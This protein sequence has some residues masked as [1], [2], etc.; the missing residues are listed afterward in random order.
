MADPPQLLSAKVEIPKFYGSAVTTTYTDDNGRKKTATIGIDDWIVAIELLATEC[1]W[2]D[3]QTATRALVGLEGDAQSWKSMMHN[4]GDECITKWATDTG[5]KAKMQAWFGSDPNPA[6][7]VS[8][9]AE[10]KQGHFSTNEGVRAFYARTAQACQKFNKKAKAPTAFTEDQKKAALKMQFEVD[11]KLRFMAGLKKDL[12]SQIFMTNTQAQIDT[13]TASQ[14]LEAAVTAESINRPA[15]S[16]TT[17]PRASATTQVNAAE[18]K[19]EEEESKGEDKETAE[20]AAMRVEFAKLKKKDEERQATAA[21][22]RARGRGGRGRGRGRG[23]GAGRGAGVTCYECGGRGHF[24]RVCPTAQGIGFGGRGGGVTP[25]THPGQF[26]APRNT[27]HDYRGR[28]EED[29][30]FPPRYGPLN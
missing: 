8:L 27:Y 10:L 15:G 17:N 12:R 23:R 1:G 25:T 14:I 19:E 4:M 5:M 20:V 6:E 28:D 11:L 3:A 18:A 13:K 24:A 22:V 21:A 26:A 16:V 9:Q 29:D 7:I 30:D 2:N